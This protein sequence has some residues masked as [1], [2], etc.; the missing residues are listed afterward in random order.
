MWSVD[1]R[2]RDVY[3]NRRARADQ[4]FSSTEQQYVAITL[5]VVVPK[6]RSKNAWGTQQYGRKQ[7]LEGRRWG[8]L[9]NRQF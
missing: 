4:G 9:Q 3:Q 7:Q 2:R 8:Q 1:K 5:G 6:K